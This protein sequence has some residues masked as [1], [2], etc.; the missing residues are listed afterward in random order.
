MEL[1]FIQPMS[2]KLSDQK[3]GEYPIDTYITCDKCNNKN[4]NPRSINTKE[5]FWHCGSD[6]NTRIGSK[7]EE[8]CT[9][10]CCVNCE[11]FEPDGDFIKM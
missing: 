2:Y 3:R 4:L 8:Y 6:K 1:S 11:P 5:G 9:Y 10:N 7:S